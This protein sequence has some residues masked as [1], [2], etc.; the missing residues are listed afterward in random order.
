MI[1]EFSYGNRFLSNFYYSP[2][3]FG[4]ELYSTVEHAYQAAKTLNP[5]ERR[6]IQLADKP[7]KA[8]N[9]GKKVT[10]RSDWETIKLKVMEELVRR[11]FNDFDY[12]LK[13]QLLAT[14]DQELIEG[15]WWGDTFWGVCNGIGE[16]QLGK[17]LMKV[18][19]ELKSNYPN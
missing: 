11:K 14:G 18:R 8:K 19:D 1:A 16:N 13:N 4:G 17:I 12:T 3:M 2:I 10:L 5:H 6:E 9:L 15:N 7:G